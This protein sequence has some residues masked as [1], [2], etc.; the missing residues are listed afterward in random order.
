MCV[1]VCMHVCMYACMHVC[2]CVC[3]YV[4]V[5][6]V[7]VVV[8]VVDGA[9]AC[10]AKHGVAA[11]SGYTP[12]VA[13]VHASVYSAQSTGDRADRNFPANPIPDHLP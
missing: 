12:G 6:V 11:P 2:M 3:V 10:T 5:V 9:Y 8:V 4:C 13:G 1:Y 7:V